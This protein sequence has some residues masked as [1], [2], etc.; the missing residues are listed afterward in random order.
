MSFPDVGVRLAVDKDQAVPVD[1]IGVGVPDL[2]KAKS[3]YDDVMPA[4][5][6]E[7]FFSVDSEFS[8]RPVGNKPGTFVFFYGDEVAAPQHI[9]FMVK[10]HA[11][12][13]AAFDAAIRA[14]GEAVHHP[15]PFPDYHENYYA[16]FWLD[17]FG[18]TLEVV[19]HQ[20]Q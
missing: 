17:P 2:G 8:Y 1:H 13:H 16:A 14:G 15:Q 4:L 7:D 6:Y 9:A 20:P 19:C 11:E 18:M 5:G 3:Y 10:T 12:V